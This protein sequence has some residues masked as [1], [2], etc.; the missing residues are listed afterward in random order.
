[1]TDER[2][3]SPQADDARLD[4]SIAIIGMAGR[5]PK[6]KTVEELWQNLVKGSECISFFEEGE[7]EPLPG[8]QAIPP[9]MRVSA[10]GVL[11]DVESFDAFFFGYNPREAELM[12]PQHRIFLECAWEA[13]ERAGHGG[14]QARPVGV[15]AGAS[16]NWYLLLNVH[17][18]R[19]SPRF[20]PDLAFLGNHGDLLA[21]RVSYKL[22]LRGPS[23]TVQTACSTSLVAVH[24]ACQ[25]L[26]TGECDMALAGGVSVVVPQ[27]RPYAA[28]PGSIMSPDGHCRAFDEKAQGTLFSNGVGVVVL[29]RLRDALA[30]GDHIHAVICGSAIN[31]DGAAKV[32]FV[33]PGVDGQAGAIRAALAMADV[34]PATI[35]YVETHGT[36][37][38]IGDQVEIRALTQ[39]FR[40]GTDGRQFC[41]LGSLKSNIG[42][43]DAA[44]GVA[45]LIKATLAVEQGL[46]PPSLH[47]TKPN[48]AIDFENSPFFVNTELRPWPTTHALRR[49]GVSSFGVGGTNAHVVLE[50]APRV[51]R[52]ARADGEQLLVLSARS[53]QALDDASRNLAEHLQRCPD[54]DLG[55][56]AFTLQVGRRHFPH[57]RMVVCRDGADAAQV[58]SSLDPKRV[59]SATHE[60]GEPGVAWMFPG[61]GAQHPGMGAELYRTLPVF[62]TW[63]DRCASLLERHLGFDLREALYPRGDRPEDEA[64][65]LTQTALAQPALFA[66]EFALAQQ[67]LAWGVR[68]A[69]MIGHS[70]GELVAA[71]LAEVFSLE[72]A[73]MLVAARGRLMQAAPAGAMI[74]VKLPEAEASAL[75]RGGVSL[76][77][78]NGPSDCVLSGPTGEIEQ[79]EAELARR[80]VASQRLKTSHAFHSSMM[81][82]AARAF[83]EIVRSVKRAPPRLPFLSNVTGKWITE[84]QATDPRYWAEHLLATVRFGDGIKAMME[85]SDRVL[86]EVGP[87]QALGRFA[88]NTLGSADVR[89]AASLPR[90]KGV[91]S[92]RAGLLEAA[93]RLWLAGASVAWEKLHGEG[94]R[95]VVLPTYPFERRRYWLDPAPTAVTT[96]ARAEQG[97]PPVERPELDAWFYAPQWKQA[98]ARARRAQGGAATRLSWLVFADDAGLSAAL[99]AELEASAYIV[100]T[101]VPGQRF[102]K[103]DKHRYVI[104]PDAREDYDALLADLRV[105]R[106]TP[107]RILH[108]WGMRDPD[109]RESVAA[110]A[111]RNLL[112]LLFL[113]QALVTEAVIHAVEFGVVTR[114]AYDVTGEEALRPETA[115]VTGPCRVVPQEL[116]NV[117]CVHID[118]SPAD[119]VEARAQLARKLV[120]EIE[121]PIQD[122]VVALRGRRRWVQSFEPVAIERPEEAR[123][124]LVPG[125]VYMITGGLGGIGLELGGY[126]ARTG[127]RALVLVGRT[128]PPP[129]ERWEAAESTRKLL[130]LEASGVEVVIEAADVADAAAMRAVAER[131]A[132][133]FGGVAGIIHAAGVGGGG[134]M[135]RRSSSEVSAVL[136]GKVHGAAVVAALASDLRARFLVFCSSMSALVGGAGQVDYCGANAFLDAFA[137]KLS[138]SKGVPAVSINW[139]TWQEVGM[140]V[141]A[142]LP[143]AMRAERDRLLREA[144]A[145]REGVEAFARALGSGLPQVAVSPRPPALTRAAV[146]ALAAAAARSGETKAALGAHERPALTTAYAAPTTETERVVAQIWE[147]IIGVEKVGIHDDFF[148]LGGHSLLAAQL[149]SRLRAA[150]GIELPLH[151]LFEVS[152][153]AELSQA[154]EEEILAE[155]EAEGA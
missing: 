48:P 104:R 137:Q 25:S 15:F 123:I 106:R 14:P 82:S 151:T 118:V 88:A 16:M 31:N 94:R 79:I 69:G 34:D 147:E 105:V 86:L 109:P 90:S 30:D 29:K 78:V 152:T 101:V 95:R 60:Q 128:P 91:S 5:F 33:A 107:D 100:T 20:D 73:L 8:E 89:G 155:A 138:A 150:F 108:L 140:A 132:A 124:P 41:A 153:V 18:R 80:D 42:H 99:A 52:S 57:R 116:P 93:G 13:L 136:R 58:L 54:L 71:C 62:R 38:V 148:Q 85:G 98:P 130:A 84:Q 11:S 9:E 83:E 45:G 81:A 55:D 23:M 67:W 113:A 17:S 102:E 121:S 21:T 22:D 75:A 61:Q 122:D 97:A 96:E 43:L 66:V 27:R 4:A 120:A 112:R 12:D 59:A 117:R 139:D 127:A 87:G 74:A 126:L 24:L 49:A 125:G 19:L 77:A 63:L 46:I 51:E 28:R 1:M 135:A 76:A 39:S 110:L 144:I 114:G 3:T 146:D 115:T 10:R 6:S 119:S 2:V 37:T 47:V 36:G 44:A 35:G 131:V 143:E 68:P 65:R 145:P 53:A 26:L 149:M 32:G 56:V 103:L 40:E 72:D 111:E 7:L 129:R 141:Q 133:R 142:V 92:E 70:L 64:L 50:E 134:A 154:I